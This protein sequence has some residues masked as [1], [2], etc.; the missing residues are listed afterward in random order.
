MDFAM[1][2][3]GKLRLAIEKQ[4]SVLWCGISFLCGFFT[5]ASSILSSVSPFGLAFV[6]AVGADY[7]LWAGAGAVIGSLR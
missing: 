1:N 5:S 6:G 4:R 2:A 3:V 7:T